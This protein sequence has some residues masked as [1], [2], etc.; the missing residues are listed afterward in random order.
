MNPR[1]GIPNAVR[2]T[3]DR[4]NPARGYLMP[5]RTRQIEETPQGATR[6]R[7]KHG[8]QRKPRKGIPDVVKTTTDRRKDR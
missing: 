8:E 7:E 5:G 3:A 2:G 4:G 1:K 6:C